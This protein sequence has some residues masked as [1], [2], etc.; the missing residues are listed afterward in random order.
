MTV[1]GPDLAAAKRLLDLVRDRGFSF[2]RIAPGEDGPLRGVRET[3][4]WCD[5]IYLGGFGD[6]CSAVRRR[7][8]SLIVPGG[9]PVAERVSGSALHVLHTVSDWPT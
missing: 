4:D 7:R 6:S 8:Y 3:V 9:L 1:D 5:E 2:Q